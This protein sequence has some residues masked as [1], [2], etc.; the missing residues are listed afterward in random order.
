MGMPKREGRGGADGTCCTMMPAALTAWL[1]CRSMRERRPVAALAP[2]TATAARPAATRASHAASHA[3]TS[4]L[5][6]FS[7]TWGATT[8]STHVGKGVLGEGG[9]DRSR[10]RAT[11]AAD[12]RRRHASI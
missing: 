7:H 2:T 9:S 11:L 10:D 5:V 6:S 4:S 1:A 8:H 12:E 3:S